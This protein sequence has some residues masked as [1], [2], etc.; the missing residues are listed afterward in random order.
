MRRP[1]RRPPGLGRK[2]G[3]AAPGETVK[4]RSHGSYGLLCPHPIALSLAHRLLSLVRS[5]GVSRFRHS[6]TATRLRDEHTEQLLTDGG[7]GASE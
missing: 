3:A 4:L 6:A 1:R 2:V 7:R 5:G